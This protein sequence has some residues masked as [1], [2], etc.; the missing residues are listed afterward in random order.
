MGDKMHTIVAISRQMASG[1][2]YIGYLLAKKLNFKYID[3]EILRRVADDLERDVNQIATYDERCSGILLKIVEG[4]SSVAS[5][6]A[7]T[8]PFQLPVYDKDLFVLE[9]KIMNQIADQYDAVIIG[10]G[11]YY[12]LREKPNVISIFIHAPVEFRVKRLMKA[13]NIGEREARL[14]IDGSDHKKTKFMR[15]IVGATWTDANNYH[16]C[17]DS[18][19]VDFDLSVEMIMKLVKGLP[20]S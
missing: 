2:S 20:E 9:C 6:A 5:E 8:P 3:R 12:V 11:G 17:I 16:L 13:R 4:F 15:D 19:V 1:G 18:S 7:C 10:R 14:M